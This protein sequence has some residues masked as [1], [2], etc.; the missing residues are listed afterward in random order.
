MGITMIRVVIADDHHLI[1]QGLRKLLAR[2]HDI[3]IVGEATDGQDA[4]DM[5][6]RLR[7]DVVVM[8][9][10]M[11]GINGI[12]A[13]RRICQS[14]A[15]TRLVVLS[16]FSDPALIRNALENGASGYVL[17]QSAS[18]ELVNAIRSV[19]SGVA[20]ESETVKHPD[21][22]SD[23]FSRDAPP[24]LTS[25]EHEILQLIAT[26]QTNRQIAGTLSISVK[27]VD[28]HRVNLMAKLNAHNLPELIRNAIKQG[29]VN[30]EH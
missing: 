6:S 1:R 4:I 23:R 25:R 13:T 19:S 7:P 12:E 26:S 30:F 21:F 10:K 24:A 15:E 27:T 5:V 29:L 3:Q 2:E 20:Y 9:V 16:M 22:A 18:E 11:P 17:K 8:D 28:N 14:N